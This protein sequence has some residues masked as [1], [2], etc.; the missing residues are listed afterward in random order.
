M[1][2]DVGRENAMGHSGHEH[3]GAA[4]V[5]DERVHQLTHAADGVDHA[6]HGP[7][8]SAGAV[9]EAHDKHAGYSVAM[10]R[11]RF[12][13]CLLLSV[14]VLFWSE[15]IQGWFGYTAPSFP[16]SARIPAILGTVVFLYGGRP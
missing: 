1:E 16:L 3:D 5:G 9:H 4:G 7:R 8:P 2:K 13:L 14:P 11:D 12:W 6:E 15:M 10:F